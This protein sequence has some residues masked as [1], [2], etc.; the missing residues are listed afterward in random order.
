MAEILWLGGW[1]SDPAAFA[2]ELRRLYPSHG[3]GFLDAHAV[4]AE[5]D[6]LA[7]RA[8]G[9]PPDAILAAWSLGSLLLHRALIAGLAPACR[10]L[11][12]CPVF[13]FCR[14][15]GPWPRAAV[16]RMARR[17][18]RDR[19]VVLAEFRVLALGAAPPPERAQAWTERAAAYPADELARGLRF[20]ADETADPAV[21]PPSARLAFL[22]SPRD[23]LSPAARGM[24]PGRAWSEYP[25]G[26]APFLDYPALTAE[27]LAGGPA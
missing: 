22:A 9:L 17:L 19:E 2:P 3:H 14:A 15:D 11:S 1:A 8:L 21:L 24:A 13:A 5:P 6:L 7:R 25:G 26:H 12:I 27:A 16:E 18:S 4:L 20:L 23:P 10:M